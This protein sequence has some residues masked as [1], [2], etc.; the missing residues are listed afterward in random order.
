MNCRN[1]IIVV[2]LLFLVGSNL[3]GQ[4]SRL[5]KKYYQSGEYEKAAVLYKKLYE[6]SPKQDIY[7]DQYVAT[8]IALED[9]GKAEKEISQELKKRPKDVQLYVTYGNLFEVQ[10][11]PEKANE[12]FRKAISELPPST[13]IINKLG[14]SFIRLAKYDL[15]LEAYE[16]GAKVMQ[17][18]NIFA[19]NLAELYRRKGDKSKM[20]SQYLHAA[21]DNPK[22][23]RTIKSSLQRYTTSDDREE[24]KKQLYEKM[25]VN[26]TS[27]IFPELLEWVFVQEKDFKRAFRQARALDRGLE[28][29]GTRVFNLANI[30]FNEGDYTAAIESFEYI[31]DQKGSANRYYIQSRTKLLKSKKLALVQQKDFPKEELDS[32]TIEY[33]AFLEEFGVNNRTSQLILDYAEFLALHADNLSVAISTLQQMVAKQSIQKDQI[34][35]AKIE[36]GNYYLMNDNIWDASLLYSQ[37][38]KAHKEEFVGEMAR[39]QNAKLF[40]YAGNFEWA[41]EQFDILKASTSK[42]ISNDAI[43]L[44]VFITA[45]LGLDST[46][47]ALSMFA[48]SELL[49]LQNKDQESILKMD[50]IAT[51]FP[52][53][54]LEDDILYRKARIFKKQKNYDQAIAFYEDIIERFPDEIKCDNSIFELAELYELIL[55]QPEKA[56]DLYEKLFLNY[57][58]STFAVEARKRYRVLRGDV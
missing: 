12:Q 50:S 21:Q 23:L 29:P 44:S 5:A 31:V 26:E 6:K 42:L 56:K 53:H 48:N 43:D 39:F 11:M 15:A 13:N 47:T 57:D 1:R 27:P 22:R 10:Y 38:D 37:V 34:A 52:E 9:Y 40:Y 3:M 17:N 30:A 14:N 45:N 8:I 58:N 51:M 32:L 36:L 7:F 33:D 41:Q 46:A 54:E 25:N 2:L 49:S 28:E 4:D 24:L 18:K 19:F 20:I 16:E 55:D 35:K